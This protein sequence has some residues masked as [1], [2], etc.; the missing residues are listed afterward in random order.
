MIRIRPLHADDLPL[1]LHLTRQAGWNQ[2]VA[3]W[4]RLLELEPDGG[5]VA[6]VEDR[7]VG[8]LVCA[9]YGAIAWMAMMLVDEAWRGRGIGRALMTH[10]LAEL[11]SRG[12]GTARLD[13]TPMG[14]PLY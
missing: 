5:F 9:R 1:G 6:V 11:E 10:A 14:R 2:T 3:D 8:T 7:P 13:A 12:V 4:R